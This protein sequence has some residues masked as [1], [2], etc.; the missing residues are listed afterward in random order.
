MNK[1]LLIVLCS[2]LPS[3][4]YLIFTLGQKALG[5][6]RR[7]LGL[8]NPEGATQATLI[9]LSVFCFGAGLFLVAWNLTTPI[10]YSQREKSLVI[11]LLFLL[12]G[13]LCLQV[14]NFIRWQTRPQ[15]PAVRRPV[16]KKVPVRGAL[17]RNYLV[18]SH[19]S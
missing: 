5:R 8:F 6:L 15:R 1:L 16:E 14:L 12:L 2:C 4:C 7:R 3:V 18:S 10:P 9:A 13:V 17:A 19:K 11:A